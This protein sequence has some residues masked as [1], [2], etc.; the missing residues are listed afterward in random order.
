MSNNSGLKSGYKYRIEVSGSEFHVIIDNGSVSINT[1]E[2]LEA[3]NVLTNQSKSSISD[4]AVKLFYKDQLISGAVEIESKPLWFGELKNGKLDTSKDAYYLIDDKN[5]KSQLL[6]IFKGSKFLLISNYSVLDSSLGIKLELRSI[7]SKTILEQEK[8]DKQ[9]LEESSKLSV[10]SSAMLCPVL[11][12]DKLMCAHGG[13]VQ[14]KSVKGKP[15]KSGDVSVILK[16]DLINAQI[17]GCSNSYL[18]VP[19]PCSIVVNIPPSALSMKKLNGDNAVMQDYASMIVT[20]KGVPLQ[21]IPK[22]NTM[23]FLSSTQSGDGDNKESDSKIELISP[24]L[25]LHYNMMN[26]D[27]FR[28]ISSSYENRNKAKFNKLFDVSNKTNGSTFEIDFGD[29]NKNDEGIS[30]YIYEL[31]SEKYSQESYIYKVFTVVV[32]YSIYEYLLLVPKIKTSLIKSMP[33]EIRVYGIGNFVDMASGYSRSVTDEFGNKKNIN[34]LSVTGSVLKSSIGMEKLRLKI[35]IDEDDSNVI[36]R[37][38]NKSKEYKCSDDKYYVKEQVNKLVQ[39]K[40]FSFNLTKYYKLHSNSTEPYGE[41]NYLIRSMQSF[42]KNKAKFDFLYKMDNIELDEE[43]LTKEFTAEEKETIARMILANISEDGLK[44]S[45]DNS[46]SLYE[47]MIEPLK[48]TDSDIVFNNIQEIIEKAKSV[49][50][51]IFEDYKKEEKALE[52]LNDNLAKNILI[53]KI[54]EIVLE[55]IFSLLSIGTSSGVNAKT[56]VRLGSIFLRFSVIGIVLFILDIVLIIIEAIKSIQGFSIGKQYALLKSYHSKISYETSSMVNS[57]SINSNDFYK[58]EDKGR[59]FLGLYNY[60]RYISYEDSGFSLDDNLYAKTL[61]YSLEIDEESYKTNVMDQEIKDYRLLDSKDKDIDIYKTAQ[62]SYYI[63]GSN[64]LQ[65]SYFHHIK[66]LLFKSS[67]LVF[68]RTSTY[69][70]VLINE[71][72]MLSYKQDNSKNKYTVIVTNSHDINDYRYKSQMFCYNSIKNSSAKDNVTAFY[73]SYRYNIDEFIENYNHNINSLI[74]NVLKSFHNLKLSSCNISNYELVSEMV[75]GSILKVTTNIRHFKVFFRMT[76]EEYLNEVKDVYSKYNI[77][78][79]TNVLSR[80]TNVVRSYNNI[81]NECR[82][83]AEYN[84]AFEDISNYKNFINDSK[85]YKYLENIRSFLGFMGSIGSLVDNF[86]LPVTDG[87]LPEHI[88]GYRNEKLSELDKYFDKVNISPNPEQEDNSIL[89][90]IKGNKNIL[91]I[92]KSVIETEY[93]LNFA[94]EKEKTKQNFNS[95]IGLNIRESF[96]RIISNFDLKIR[97]LIPKIDLNNNAGASNINNFIDREAISNFITQDVKESLYVSVEKYIPISSVSMERVFDNKEY[98]R[99]LCEYIYVEYFKSLKTD[100]LSELDV[101]FEFLLSYSK[102]IVIDMI[103]IHTSNYI[104]SVVEKISLFHPN[105]AELTLDDLKWLID[106]NS[107]SC[108]EYKD[109][110]FN[111][112]LYKMLLL[113]EKKDEDQLKDLFEGLKDDKAKISEKIE[114]LF[115]ETVQFVKHCLDTLYENIEEM[116]TINQ[117][118]ILEYASEYLNITNFTGDVSKGTTGII[119]ML[120]LFGVKGR[121]KYSLAVFRGVLDIVDSENISE[122]LIRYFKAKRNNGSGNSSRSF[123][124][125]LKAQYREAV[126]SGANQ[127]SKFNNLLNTFKHGGI[128]E[129]YKKVKEDIKKDVINYKKYLEMNYKKTVEFIHYTTVKIRMNF[130]D[131]SE[132]QELL[133]EYIEDKIERV[134]GREARVVGKKITEKIEGKGRRSY[135]TIEVDG[136]Q[137]SKIKVTSKPNKQLNVLRDQHI[138]SM[139]QIVEEY[140]DVNIDSARAITKNIGNIGLSVALDIIVDSLYPTIDKELYERNRNVVEFSYISKRANRLGSIWNEN[141]RYFTIPRNIVQNYIMADLTSM[142]AG[143]S[144]FDNNCFV[145]GSSS[146]LFIQN[147][148]VVTRDYVDLLLDSLYQI[149]AIDLDNKVG[150]YIIAYYNVIVYLHQMVAS[151]RPSYKKIDSYKHAVET[152]LSKYGYYFENQFV[153]DA[154]DNEE[155]YLINNKKYKK[156]DKLSRKDFVCQLQRVGESNYKFYTSQE[157]SSEKTKLLNN[158]NIKYDNEEIPVLLGSLIYDTNWF[159]SNIDN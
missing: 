42:I 97:N 54:S 76:L 80:L 10:S 67:S 109:V 125:I 16:S 3:I 104:Y 88:E 94:E 133:K 17:C 61:Y 32:D 131:V 103:Y 96:D 72:M 152:Y 19:Q 40:D 55:S 154:E 142:V 73:T 87:E 146:A 112:L 35:N 114:E 34:I 120:N 4:Y 145:N 138:G 1:K 84:K 157:E 110:A 70:S 124:E 158:E 126:I 57:G 118:T 38:D 51:K 150:K 18:G 37:K 26:V 69:S 39:M 128:G 2:V 108:E 85:Y 91:S 102:K 7:E 49:S 48:N 15:F 62:L 115:S 117:D 89:S 68:L 130:L 50:E 47:K 30:S 77:N 135:Y 29:A 153:I 14:L 132:A 156:V 101:S 20:D 147:D 106:E 79:A 143:G 56:L 25:S 8:L 159:K 44:K 148:E 82:S 23:K 46:I 137:V 43:E 75:L 123:M 31:Y 41:D 136:K 27:K 22:P 93:S 119:F 127:D 121:L 5:S 105:F 122:V 36:K 60:N 98:Y 95:I 52:K 13:Q 107:K 6:K 129:L 74:S 59:Y 90:F 151:C 140:K 111:I 134:T 83:K 33:K 86:Y 63:E 12:D 58:I 149:N 155:D 92:C 45:F 99:M 139:S 141:K 66:N 100:I 9:K 81:L 113:S 21:I 64:I 28:I 71:L 144:H 53:K 24:I 116:F 11:E 65:S 78:S